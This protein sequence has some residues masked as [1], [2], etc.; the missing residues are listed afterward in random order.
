MA[1]KPYTSIDKIK[2]AHTLLPQSVTSDAT[3]ITVDTNG[4]D[5]VGLCLT[6]GTIATADA[7]NTLAVV[8]QEDDAANMGTVATVTG[9][10]AIQGTLTNPIVATTGDEVTYTWNYTGG[11]RYL[12][13]KIDIT[14]TV[15]G[16][17][18]A[19]VVMGH[20]KKAP[21]S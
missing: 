5:S 21:V 20:P 2:I 12:R 1:I 7:D 3:G 11:K 13:C 14:G 9:L 4:Y 15:E 19:Y 10:T 8:W 17:F 6:V 16:L 18:S